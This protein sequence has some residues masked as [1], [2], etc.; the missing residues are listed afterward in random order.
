MRGFSIVGEVV[1]QS[2][3]VQAGHTGMVCV[4]STKKHSKVKETTLMICWWFASPRGCV[5]SF[6]IFF[7]N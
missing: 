4:F 6:M 1:A 2:Y 7:Y 5:F 3:A